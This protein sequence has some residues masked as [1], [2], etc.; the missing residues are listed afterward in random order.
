MKL[1]FAERLKELTGKTLGKEVR[2]DIS[3]Y[4]RNAVMGKLEPFPEQM[5][6]G[7]VLL[8]AVTA[9][10]QT[11]ANDVARFVT[12]AASHWPISE[13]DG[14]AALPFLFHY[15]KSIVAQSID[16]L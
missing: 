8:F 13:W 1:F 12:H 9:P 2:I 10:E 4:G 14:S 3:Q 5:P 7:L 16:S 11:L 15:W 6:H